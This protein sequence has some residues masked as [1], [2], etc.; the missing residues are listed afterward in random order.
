MNY[1]ISWPKKSRN[2]CVKS[3]NN[4]A[5]GRRAATTEM[6]RNVIH[7]E[8][9]SF[10]KKKKTWK[11]IVTY[12]TDSIPTIKNLLNVSIYVI[13]IEWESLWSMTVDKYNTPL[14]LCIFP[15]RLRKCWI[16]WFQ[17]GTQG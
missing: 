9:R 7:A 5:I 17:L 4:E 16:N 10:D 13:I 2:A 12:F 3:A 15:K 8:M 6:S 14:S 1:Q 11:N